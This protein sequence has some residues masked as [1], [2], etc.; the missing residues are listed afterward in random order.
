[1][2]ASRW[3]RI[4]KQKTRRRRV[5]KFFLIFLIVGFLTCSYWL[6]FSGYFNISNFEIQGLDVLSKEQVQ[7]SLNS[8]FEQSP[9]SFVSAKNWFLF[10]ADSFKRYLQEKHPLLT[11]ISLQKEFPDTLRIIVKEREPVFIACSST[12]LG[13]CFY[14][15]EAGTVYEEAPQTEGS[16]ITT[17][18]VSQIFEKGTSI[19][20]P[21]LIEKLI[22][23]KDLLKKRLSLPTKKIIVARDITFETYEGWQIKLDAKSNFLE[24]FDDLV[25][26]LNTQLKGEREKLEYID[27]TIPNRAYYK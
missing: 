8:F 9:S 19:L 1:M 15:D 5:L 17:V 23:F 26:L 12:Q 18:E 2:D 11:S 20:D 14:I 10:S 27:L 16:L 7:A 24:R 6:F 4:Y 25:L 13:S 21:A 22:I 3:E